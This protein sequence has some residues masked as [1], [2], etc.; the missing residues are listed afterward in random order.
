LGTNL[1]CHNQPE[2]V[3]FVTQPGNS[4]HIIIGIAVLFLARTVV[5]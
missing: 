1:A 5:H 4:S 3:T 2:N